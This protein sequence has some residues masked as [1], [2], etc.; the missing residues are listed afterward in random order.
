MDTKSLFPIIRNVCYG[1]QHLEKRL[2]LGTVVRCRFCDWTFPLN[3]RTVHMAPDEMQIVCCPK[4][5]RN[6]SILY[7]FDNTVA[8]EKKWTP[9]KRKTDDGRMKHMY[10]N[11]RLS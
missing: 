7:F 5:R 1:H 2:D 8:D 10:V 3:D 6:V 4:C 11:S 9:V